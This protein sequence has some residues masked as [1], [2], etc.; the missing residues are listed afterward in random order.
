MIKQ[1]SE[2]V[3]FAAVENS[4]TTFDKV[5]YFAVVRMLD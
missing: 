4:I 5:A 3:Y 1:A 2:N